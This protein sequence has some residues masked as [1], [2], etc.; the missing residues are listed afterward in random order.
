MRND[1]QTRRRVPTEIALDLISPKV[2][3]ATDQIQFMI[4]EFNLNLL[5]SNCYYQ[6]TRAFNIYNSNTI[7]IVQS[8]SDEISQ[9]KIYRKYICVV[10]LNDLFL[11]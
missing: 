11:F 2:M 4:E 7:I 3:S 10:V 9:K 1:F 5:M 8:S 6:L